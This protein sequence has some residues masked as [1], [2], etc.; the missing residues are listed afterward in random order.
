MYCA[1]IRVL[2]SVETSSTC[3]FGEFDGSVVVP[4]LSACLNLCAFFGKRAAGRDQ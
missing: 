1:P 3:G 2:K 4:R